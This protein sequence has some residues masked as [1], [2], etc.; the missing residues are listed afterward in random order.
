MRRASINAHQSYGLGT[1]RLPSN[2]SAQR[3][4]VD[5][6][7]DIARSRLNHALEIMGQ[8]VAALGDADEDRTS[9]N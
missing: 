3:G 4:A 6:V 5:R 2:A 8:Y 7:S 1:T 9:T